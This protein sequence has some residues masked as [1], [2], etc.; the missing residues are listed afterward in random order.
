MPSP[1]PWKRSPTSRANSASLAAV[2]LAQA[3]DAEDLVVAGRGVLAVGHQGHLA[4]VVDEADPGQAVV[5]DARA[6]LHRVE[7]AERDASARRASRGTATSSGSSSG[8]IG[9]ITSARAV[10]GGPGGDVLRRIGADGGP[11]Q[12]VARRRPGR[13]RSPGRRAPASR[14]GE[15]SN[16]LMSISLIQGCSTTSWLKR[17]R[18]CSSAARSTGWRPR[19]PFERREDPGLLHHPPGQRRV[20]RRQGQR[21]VLED[22]DELAAGA[23]EQHRA[24]LRVEA[25]ADDQLVAVEPDHRLDG[26]ALEVP[27]AGALARP[28]TRSRR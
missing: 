16:G 4:V 12:L 25:A 20:Q 24:E 6:Q 10:L 5:G 9:R 26:H 8:R 14:S 22:L 1:W 7:V 15:A 17:T 19:T 2:E 18:S 27:G 28:T 13:G 3:A 11:G 21:A 23:E